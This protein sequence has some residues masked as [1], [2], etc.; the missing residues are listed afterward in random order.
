VN[1]GKKKQVALNNVKNKLIHIITAMV[2][3]NQPFDP[4]YI[5][6]NKSIA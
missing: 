3:N 1:K 5:N 6:N 2:K 4:E